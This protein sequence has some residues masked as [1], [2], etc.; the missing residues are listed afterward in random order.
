VELNTRALKKQLMA[1]F[2]MDDI[3]Q[4]RRYLDS[5]TFS[6]GAL[7]KVTRIPVET[8]AYKGAW[9]VP[10]DAETG[11]TLLYLH[12]GGYTFYPKAY[13]NLIALIALAAK[14]RTFV[15]DYRLAPEHRFPAQLEDALSA[16]RGLLADGADPRGL[17]VAG[18]SAGGNLALALLLE[19]RDRQLPLAALAA[20]LS[21]ATDFDPPMKE[22]RG[23]FLVNEPFDWVDSR[24]LLQ[25]ADWFCSPAQRHDPRVSPVRANLRGL[26]PFYIQAG[27]AEILYD[28]IRT[29]ATEAERQ[30][31]NVRLESWPEMNHDFQMFGYQAPQSAEALRRLGAVISGIGREGS[32]IKAL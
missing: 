7:N 27:A 28:S 29:F 17:A 32:P 1:A 19:A 11:V 31:A 12:G 16:Y 9:F 14:C 20:L 3:K 18:D 8:A 30:G 2:K 15:L 25:W 24:M 5:L 22:E 4:A 23:S 21:P 13:A 26:P 10:K 6:S